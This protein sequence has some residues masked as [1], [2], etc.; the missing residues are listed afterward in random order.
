MTSSDM[1]SLDSALLRGIDSETMLRTGRS[2]FGEDQ[3]GV[4]DVVTK[5][6][7]LT[8]AAVVNSFVN[9]PAALLR[10]FGADVSP[11]VSMGDWG[12]DTDTLQYYED[13]KVAIEGAALV[14][15]S[16]L[17]GFG[18]LKLLKL[19]QEGKMGGAMVQAATGIFSAREAAYTEKAIS[20]IKAGEATLFSA[21]RGDMWRAIGFGFGEQALQAGV[22]EVATLATMKGNYTL[23]SL[24]PGQMTEN[25]LKGAVVGGIIGGALSSL[26]TVG[27]IKKP[28]IDTELSDRMYELF[29]LTGQLKMLTGDKVDKLWSSMLDIADMSATMTRPQASKFAAAQRQAQGQ[30]TEMLAGAASGDTRLAYELT[31]RMQEHIGLLHSTLGKDKAAD[32]LDNIFSKVKSIS[33]INE[34]LAVDA[35]QPTHMLQFERGKDNIIRGFFTPDPAHIDSF[36]KPYSPKAATADSVF[37]ATA[38]G[39]PPIISLSGVQHNSAKEAFDAGAEVYITRK[40]TVIVNK[41]AAREVLHVPLPGANRPINVAEASARTNV[42]VG[43]AVGTTAINSTK[44]SFTKAGYL[45]LSTGEL[46]DT[47]FKH[48]TIADEAAVQL[49]SKDAIKYGKNA[50]DKFKLDLPYADVWLLD[51][52]ARDVSKRWAWAAAN[53]AS[54]ANMRDLF[55]GSENIVEEFDLPALELLRNHIKSDRNLLSL[56]QLDNIAPLVRHVDSTGAEH[57]ITLQAYMQDRLPMLAADTFPVEAMNQLIQRNKE[58]MLSRLLSK[59]ASMDEIALK[60]NAT[61]AELGR[62]QVKDGPLADYTRPVRLRLN[63]DLSQVAA[64]D[65]NIVKG[66]VE[67]QV[68]MQQA[69]D[70]ARTVAA[71]FF[72]PR[73][74]SINVSKVGAENATSFGAGQGALTSAN[75]DALTLGGRMKYMGAQLH[76][77]KMETHQ[78]TATELKEKFLAVVANPAAGS[79]VAALRSQMQRTGGQ[80]AFFSAHNADDLAMLQKMVDNG[81]DFGDHTAMINQWLSGSAQAGTGQGRGIALSMDAISDSMGPGVKFMHTAMP[82]EPGFVIVGGSDAAAAAASN[83]PVK[84]TA[85]VVNTDEAAHALS[86]HTRLA[87]ARSALEERAREAQGYAMRNP[88][89]GSEFEGRILY[90]PPIPT[91]RYSHYKFVRALQGD[92]TE[93]GEQTS[94]IFGRTAEELLEKEQLIDK[95]KYQVLSRQEVKNWHKYMGDYSADLDMN[96]LFTKS[97]LRKSGA[98]ADKYPRMNTEEMMTDLMSWHQKADTQVIQRYAELANADL[99]AQLRSLGDQWKSAMQSKFPTKDADTLS[100]P[101][102]SYLKL[103]LDVAQKD[104]LPDYFKWQQFAEDKASTVIQ[105]LMKMFGA[106][107]PTAEQYAEATAALKRM[108]MGN[109]YAATIEAGMEMKAFSGAISMVP[110]QYLAKF[111]GAVNTTV[112]TLGIRLDVIQSAIN[113]IS[114]P[115][116]LVLQTEGARAAALDDLRVR[117][118]GTQHTLPGTSKLMYQAMQDVT[119]GPNRRALLARYERIGTVRSKAA[120]FIDMYDEIALPI[121]PTVEV[122]EQKISNLA[123][124]GAKATL[125][126]QSE[127]FTRLL[128]SR[129]GELLYSKLGYTGADLDSLIYTFATRVNGNHLTSQRPLMFQGWLGQSIGLYQTYQ[130]NLLQQMFRNVQTGQKKSVLFALGMQQTLFGLQGLPGFHAINQHLIGNAEGNSAHHDLYSEVPSYFSKDVGEFLLYGGVSSLTRAGVYTRGD[131][132]PRQI[133][134]L[135]VLPTD[136][137]G[138]SVLSRTVGNTLDMFKKISGGGDILPSLLHAVEHNGMNRMIQGMAQVAGGV[139][140]TSSGSLLSLTRP[141]NAGLLDVLSIANTARMLGARPLDEAIALD[142]N[143]RKV[144]Y[145]MADVQRMEELG[146]VVKSKLI[147]GDNL[148]PDEISTIATKYAAAGGRLE[149]FGRK[150]VSWEKD[151]HRSVANQAFYG[152]QNPISQRAQMIMGGR[153]LPDYRNTWQSPEAAAESGVTETEA[154]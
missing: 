18:S 114:T 123:E 44:R 138:L 78:K 87:G 47:P 132:S 57:T 24:T 107:K 69:Y 14:A 39:A 50:V 110:K 118:P 92:I 103:G 148:D 28:F 126:D 99:F 56:D 21:V 26:S 79:E 144:A 71:S 11:T 98:L 133:T 67:Q 32:V 4:A 38:D 65:G 51:N 66:R 62:M 108:G 73:F 15:G 86:A 3:W 20:A 53:S 59:G 105:G 41:D 129:T 30:M 8:A 154:P 140:T 64:V 153:Q 135:P 25:V 45:D 149:T 1:N 97:D 42:G 85:Y 141:P 146:Q 10:T 120:D 9:T 125:S 84:Y 136:W 27:K 31:T 13:K 143:Y 151:A 122:L 34:E 128:A 96:S 37:F 109:P 7:P 16:L 112:A 55:R 104:K 49:V 52:S 102:D 117:V 119:T 74:E 54:P 61:K 60:L 17:P 75:E 12:F 58:E 113:A 94:M 19:A 116:M 70:H 77:L 100:N 23:E 43:D 147:N 95:S 63:Y 145:Q 150:L 124:L 115:V 134:V 152:A 88:W 90:F 89:L 80:Y 48:F 93:G 131:I 72:G 130:L 22:W 68:R 6:V 139:T 81:A 40:G 33:R 121:H 111:T 91:N 35:I 36:V 137:P 127:I 83:V 46:F 2:A 106:G 29:D 5:G 101:F 76:A 82:N 142:E